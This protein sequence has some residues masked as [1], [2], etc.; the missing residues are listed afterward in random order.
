MRSL[1]WL[2]RGLVFLLLFGFAV[3]NDEVVTLRFFFGSEWHLPLVFV[4]LVFFAAGIVLGATATLASWF[5]Q[6]REIGRL[7]KALRRAEREQAR[8]PAVI[9]GDS[10]EAY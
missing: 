9:D 5:R 8:P 2:F 3:K 4:M 6:W 1:I 7:R 10:S